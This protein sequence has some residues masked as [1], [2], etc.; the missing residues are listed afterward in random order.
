MFHNNAGIFRTPHTAIMPVHLPTNV[1]CCFIRE[2]KVPCSYRPR[3]YPLAWQST[4]F[5]SY[6]IFLQKLFQTFDVVCTVYLTFAQYIVHRE[7]WD[8]ELSYRI[9]RASKES[10][11]YDVHFTQWL[12]GDPRLF[13]L[14]SP[15]V[16]SNYSTVA[17]CV[18]RIWRCP[19]NSFSPS[20]NTCNSFHFCHMPRTQ[21][22]VALIPFSEQL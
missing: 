16:A 22:S 19:H 7:S 4:F 3:A 10:L 15:P 6:L 11:Q 12:D 9:S 17:G 13:L 5:A 2:Y 1:K 21:P 14:F 8:A 20:L 18:V